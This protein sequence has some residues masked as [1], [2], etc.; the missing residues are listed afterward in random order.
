MAILATGNTFADGDQVT[1]TTLNNI[2]NAATFAADAVDDSTTE[3]SSGKIIIKDGGVTP[4]KLSTNHP[5]WDSTGLGVGTSSPS[6]KLDV[7]SSSSSA[8]GVD[9]NN[10]STGDPV[11]GF[12]LA[13][14][15]KFVMGV[16]N[17][18]SDKFK[19]GTT[20]VETS[21]CLTIDSTGPKLTIGSG[22]AA[23]TA[24]IFDGNAQDYYIAL[25]D[26]AD[27]LLIGLGSTIG[28]TPAISIDENLQSTFGGDVI[29]GGTTPTLTI[30][31]AGAEDTAIVFDG[32]AKDFYIALD[33][34]A[35]KLVIGEGSTVGTNSILTITDDSVT[36]G[37]ASAVDTKIV[38]DGNAQD[39]Y[40][41]LDDSADDLVIGLGSTVGTT[42][43]ISVDENQLATFGAGITSTAAANT[44]GATSFND[45]DITNVGAIALD[46]ITNDGTDVTIDS[47]N[48]IVLDADGAQVR[49][50]DAGTERFVFNLDATPELDVTG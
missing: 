15:S 9:I 30:G 31:D 23:D 1:S 4:A 18:D 41:G 35:D 14:T 13:G 6:S 50:K 26:S 16:D 42:P 3:L 2:A 7:E 10:T 19:I 8:D 21:T 46:T 32:N 47:S 43:S 20:A 17:S 45:A 37:D 44:L 29:I 49:F 28:T 25:D 48:D 38:F 34:S 39:F 11:L 22:A 40:I 33:D 27:D 12:Q 5:N 36:I 24:I